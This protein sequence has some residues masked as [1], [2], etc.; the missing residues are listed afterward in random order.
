MWCEGQRTGRIG[1]GGNER[2]GK[3][4]EQVGEAWEGRMRQEVQR[5]VT[6]AWKGS[7]GVYIGI[8]IRMGL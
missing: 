7:K 1:L 4:K 8:G 2:G 6:D 5:I 3:F